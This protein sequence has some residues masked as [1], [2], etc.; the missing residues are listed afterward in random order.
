MAGLATD[1]QEVLLPTEKF[2][3]QILKPRCD[4]ATGAAND[5][6]VNVA[7]LTI[8]VVLANPYRGRERVC[9]PNT[10]QNRYLW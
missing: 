6:P 10:S 1:L 9:R 4:T 8:I 7:L 5:W 3:S 2:P